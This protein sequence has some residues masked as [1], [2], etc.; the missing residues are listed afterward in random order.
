MTTQDTYIGYTGFAD[1]VPKKRRI[2]VRRILMGGSIGDHGR[3]P[4]YLAF[5]LLG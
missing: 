4:R 1:V 5:S 3:L 2:S